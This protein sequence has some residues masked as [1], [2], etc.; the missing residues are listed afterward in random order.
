MG[1]NRKPWSKT[2]RYS[3][4]IFTFTLVESIVFQMYYYKPIDQDKARLE[5]AKVL[6]LLFEMI[7]RFL[8]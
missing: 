5:L 1:S 4:Y 8:S 2:R 6:N 7:E 3:L